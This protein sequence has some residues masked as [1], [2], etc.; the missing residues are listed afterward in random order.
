M[1]STK[2]KAGRR[3]ALSF[4]IVTLGLDVGVN[5]LS[6]LLGE[7]H[8]PDMVGTILT[9]VLMFFLWRGSALAWWLSC[10]SLFL[11]LSFATYVTWSGNFEVGG[12]LLVL[13]SSLTILLVL[14]AT[15]AFFAMQRLE[16]KAGNPID[17]KP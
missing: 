2:L 1:Y 12:G 5:L 9:F 4:V 15:R 13:F 17:L 8:G 3:Y 6:L 7:L 14:P 11:S 10:V 16:N